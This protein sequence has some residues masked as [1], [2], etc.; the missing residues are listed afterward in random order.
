MAKDGVRISWSG[1][2]LYRTRRWRADMTNDGVRIWQTMA[3][4][5][6]RRWRADT[7]DI[8]YRTTYIYKNLLQKQCLKNLYIPN[9]EVGGLCS[10][11]G[12]LSVRPSVRSLQVVI[13]IRFL[14]N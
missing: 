13:L 9:H 7:M 1:H 6:G 2:I 12:G 10:R 11:N 5:Y 8:L 4:G 3:C 14:S